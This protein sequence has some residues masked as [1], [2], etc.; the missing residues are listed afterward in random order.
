[1]YVYIGCDITILPTKELLVDTRHLQQSSACARA[2]LL[3]PLHFRA[4][5]DALEN[6]ELWD[7]RE[8]GWEKFY[9]SR[10]PVGGSA[11]PQETLISV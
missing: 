2:I 3:R 6:K 7:R 1:M 5:K 11:W 4:N 9:P 10:A 8:S